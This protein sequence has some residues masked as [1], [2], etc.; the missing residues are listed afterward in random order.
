MRRSDAVA[1]GGVQGGSALWSG[2]GGC[3]EREAS[4]SSASLSADD[5]A[6]RSQALA[7]VLKCEACGGGE[8]D[9]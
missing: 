7:A 4:G 3:V 2:G 6:K 9:G 5:D 1:R 8:A